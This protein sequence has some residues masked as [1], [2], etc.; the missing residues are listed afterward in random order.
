[1]SK[2]S[3]ILFAVTFLCWLGFV[4]SVRRSP[5]RLIN[6]FLLLFD[7]ILTAVSCAALC[8]DSAAQ[9][10]V[11]GF[12]ALFFVLF[13]VPLI[14]IWNGIVMI[15][16]ESARLS[17]ILSLLLGVVIAAGEAAFLLFAFNG[18]GFAFS[19]LSWVSF[20]VGAS[21]FYG[22]VLLLAFV[23]YD[24]LLPF[25]MRKEQ[26][27]GLIV[28][29]CALI[30]GDKVSRILSRRLDLAASLHRLGRETGLIVVSGG[31]GDDET[32]SEAAAMRNYLIKKGVCEDRI[33][34]EDQSRST[35]ENLLYSSQL[36]DTGS[37]K[38]TAII[39]SNYHLYR[40]L[41]TAKELGIRCRGYGSPVA[42]YY[43]P[44]AVIREFAAVYSR[45]R[46]FLPALA[47]YGFFVIL[48]LLLLAAT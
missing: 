41:L 37:G 6:S 16:R 17:N 10:L 3:C 27:D 34:K 44:S 23:L 2:A 9:A 31:K 12:F 20:F 1:M 11:I 15:R 30:H 47:G 29:G 24:F 19:D 35:R 38:K 25:L 8:G 21:V 5:E 43:W 33:L 28:H 36:I 7:L 22:S 40:C 26:Y 48:P 14:L 42:A 39:T 46:Y 18:D 32:V 45:R 13:L 4:L